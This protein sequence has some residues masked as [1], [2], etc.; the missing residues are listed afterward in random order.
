MYILLSIVFTYEFHCSS[1][2][3]YGKYHM[4]HLF[5]RVVTFLYMRKR[6]KLG[7]YG[8]L[9][10]NAAHIIERQVPEHIS[11]FPMRG[12]WH[13]IKM[14]RTSKSRLPQILIQLLVASPNIDIKKSLR[15][16]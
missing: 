9:R 6:V 7:E 12:L 1:I 3:S 8:Q 2:Q 11:Y 13:I 16:S 4:K 15:V 10:V 5:V 14:H